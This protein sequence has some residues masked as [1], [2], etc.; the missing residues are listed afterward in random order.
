MNLRTEQG[1]YRTVKRAKTQFAAIANLAANSNTA[2][3]GDE[4]CFFKIYCDDVTN[5]PA[6]TLIQP[7]INGGPIYAPDG[8]IISLTTPT[9]KFT[10]IVPL[11]VGTG[12][13]SIHLSAN[14]T[15]IVEF[16]ITA[17]ERVEF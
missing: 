10:W 14:T 15:G 2:D 9:T 12:K 3:F 13:L 4:Y 5:I 8:T 16:E 6:A 1:K 11:L 7:Y 17:Y